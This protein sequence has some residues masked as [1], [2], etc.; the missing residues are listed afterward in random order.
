MRT[1]RHETGHSALVEC[2]E[3]PLLRACALHARQLVDDDAREASND[4]HDE[5]HR[6]K[7]YV[8]DHLCGKEDGHGDSHED[9]GQGDDEGEHEH[10]SRIRGH[11]G[12]HGS[13]GGRKEAE[14]AKDGGKHQGNAP[15]ASEQ[16]PNA[17]DDGGKAYGH[18][19]QTANLESFALRRHGA[20]LFLRRYVI[21][22]V[23]SVANRGSC[24]GRPSREAVGW[25][26]PAQTSPLPTMPNS[27]W[28]WGNVL[29]VS[30]PH[31]RLAQG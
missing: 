12:Q 11:I 19:N 18:G 3:A 29:V 31:G 5:R 10:P 23:P 21:S 8:G 14:H 30:L 22:H 4:E 25:R 20:S 27:R 1:V 15:R 6:R 2:P 17:N 13:T 9:A 24:A 7:Q 16:E 26:R 28:L